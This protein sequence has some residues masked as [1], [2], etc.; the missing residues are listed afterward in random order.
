[1]NLH[2]SPQA[3]QDAM[4]SK[5]A[6][7]PIPVVAVTDPSAEK[8]ISLIPYFNM[9]DVNGFTEAEE[10]LTMMRG[11]M[12]AAKGQRTLTMET[13]TTDKGRSI[14]A[15]YVASHGTDITLKLT[16][17][18]SATIPLST[19]SEESQKRAAELAE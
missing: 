12:V 15:T 3:V 4:Y 8:L 9:K 18:K 14:A 1:M 2:K 17:G 5:E 6:R 7:G 11:E 16:N 19:L 10:G 13:W